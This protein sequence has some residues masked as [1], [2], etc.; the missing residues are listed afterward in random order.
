VRPG[1]RRQSVQPSASATELA[2]GADF[3]VF[4]ASPA[5]SALIVVYG[6]PAFDGKECC[7]LMH[8]I[9]WKDYGQPPRRQGLTAL[10]AARCA[11]GIKKLRRAAPSASTR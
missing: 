4:E 1:G 6:P 7:P 10:I 3:S 9:Y 5:A 2:F 8:Q 11:T